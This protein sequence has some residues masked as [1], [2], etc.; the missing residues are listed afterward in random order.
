MDQD[1]VKKMIEA[2]K[3]Y[4]FK[5]YSQQDIADKL[6]VSRPTVSRFLQQAKE[7][8]FV[9]IRIMDPSEDTENL[10]YRLKQ[11]YNLAKV[12]VVS[13]PHYE[14][15]LIREYLA[16][17][18]ALYLDEIIKDDDSLVLAWGQLMHQI[19]KKLHHKHVNHVSIVQMLGGFTHLE[20]NRYQ[21][22][23]LH[24]FA[25]ALDSH[26]YF[27]P[28]PAIVDHVL[29]KQAMESDKYI[30][31]ILEM[32][33]Q[34]NIA[35]FTVDTSHSDSA[36]LQSDY[37][38][39]EDRTEIKLKSAGY[40]GTRFYDKNG[41]LCLSE[42]STRMIGLELEEL[43]RKERS[44]LVAGGAEKVE[45]IYGA[46]NG[47]FANVLITDQLTAKSLLE[48]DQELNS[49]IDPSNAFPLSGI[50]LY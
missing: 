37:F 22:E 49:R 42:L 8:G 39:N 43:K 48:K 38:S 17:D 3:M 2:A 10:A 1:K 47:R 13:V 35:L 5:D 32:G 14:E 26:P 30:R 25:Q 9:Q 15:N 21:S 46:L 34:A 18:T 6:G 19:A 4:Y 41:Q 33:K 20:D 44:I 11:K 45:A 29:V 27:L 23:I 28:L 16:E 40:I 12:I 24:L 31:K 7:D 36:F 50:P